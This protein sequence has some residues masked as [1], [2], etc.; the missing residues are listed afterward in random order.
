MSRRRMKARLM[1]AF[2]LRYARYA[3]SIL[4]SVGFGTH[5]N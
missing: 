3:A 5:L 4:S 1:I 2:T